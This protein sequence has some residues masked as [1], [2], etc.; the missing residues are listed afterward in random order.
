[1]PKK[2]RLP[3]CSVQPTEQVTSPREGGARSPRR[4]LRSRQGNAGV[5]VNIGEGSTS[6]IVA[7][8]PV[9][10]ASYSISLC[11]DKRCF[12][13]KTFKLEKHVTS[14][15]THRKYKVINHTGENLNCHSQN[16]VYLCTCLCCN[17]QYV[18]ETAIPFHK[19]NNIHRTGKSGCEHMIHHCKEACNGYQFKYHILEKLP[20]TGYLPSGEL[21][22]EMS[23]LRK[24]KED[25]WMKKMRTIYPYGL[26][27][28]AN[29][30]E[31]NSSIV[32]PAIGRLFPPL[33]RNGDR[34]ERSRESRLS[35]ASNISCHEFFEKLNDLLHQDLK[36]SYNEVRKMLNRI[37][38]KVLKEIAFHIM[39]RDTFTFIENKFQVYH[40]ILDIIDTKLLKPE[41]V[42]E[43]KA[44]P[45]N[46][47]VIDFVNK[48][49]DDIHLSKI[50]RSQEVTELLPEAL[51]AEDEI[52]VS[53][54]KLNPPIRSKILNYK[55]TVSSL[56]T[57][58][59]ED[60]SFI[61]NLP[62]CDCINSE[63]CDPHHKHIV[64]GDLRIITNTKLRKLISKGPNYR[65]PKMLNYHKCK[66]SIESSITS[67]IDALAA[68]YN[69][70]VNSFLAWKN[71]ILEL[72]EDKIRVLKSKKVPSVIKPI[73]QDEVVKNALTDLH[74][75]FVI[76]PIDKASNNVALIC[77]RFY[78][79]KLLNEVGVPGDASSTYKLSDKDPNEIVQN[80][81]EYCEKLG[82]NLEDRLKTLPFMYWLPKMHYNPPR[83][84]FIIASS[85]CSTKPLSKMASSI[86]KHIFNQV[87]NFHQKSYFYKNYNRFWVIENSSP[88]LEKL[89]RINEKKNARDIS[90]YDFSTLYTKL[91][92]DDLIKNLNEI[93]DFAFKGGNE[94]KDGNRKY[95]T[96][97]GCS[98][99]WSKKKKGKNSFTKGDIKLLVSYLIRETYFQIGNLLFRQCIGIP[100]G[101]D[102][103]PHWANLHLYSYEYK[104]IK[105]LM[106]TNPQKAMKFRYAVRFIDDN[107]NLNDGGEFGRSYHL[108]YPADLELKCEHQG[109]HA[110]FLDLEINIKNNIYV[111]K[112]FDKR[113]NFPFFIVR[114][115][116]LGGNIPSHVFYGSVMSEFLR[117][118]RS[119]LL[120]S[121]FLPSAISLFKRM[122]NQGGSACFI[123][124]QICKAVNRH[125]Q[126]F[127]K[128]SKSAQ[129]IVDDI[130]SG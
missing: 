31:T 130:S 36:N 25:E 124:K 34:A 115:P 86:F 91:Q 28:K 88:V 94:K 85:T 20:G 129:E 73:L 119:T 55:E 70:P 7:R 100:M 1:M 3:A 95:L 78:I 56:N 66:Q 49:L 127:V 104:F 11:K 44:A 74:K 67:A 38:K 9:S 51:K 27:E 120:Y 22:P 21:D 76:V 68:K 116:D 81:S 65:E 98:A 118:A 96:L 32:E 111:Y 45:K 123:L 4:V 59:D 46:V 54:M 19:R 53:T 105:N 109:L 125:P 47:I 24:S 99:F 18:G 6:F 71:K 62:S 126:P 15:T 82:I 92:H 90:T 30:K 35:H 79:Q 17:I 50:F 48:G 121:D 128:F 63:F 80:N 102:P 16:I 33:S 8:G 103:A 107:C 12:T 97:S 89:T 52:P 5:I 75:R 113:E 40:Y 122:T 23:K 13:C 10:D 61:E 87:R 57:F 42:V 106:K 72:V 83:A 2:T 108:I 112:L 84:R 69:V 39:E 37:K 64:S 41:V 43:K 93:V 77:K 117:I 29:D 26:N 110:T 114:M 58:V 101:I 14:N 60:V